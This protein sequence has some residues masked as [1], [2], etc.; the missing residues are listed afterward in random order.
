MSWFI[1]PL[2]P[3]DG[4]DMARLHQRAIMAT[5]EDFYS[6]EQRRSWCFGL[7]PGQYR[8]PDGGHFDVV[9]A[10]AA[11][12]AFCDHIADEVVGLYI[13]PDWQGRGIGSALMRQA[14]GRMIALGTMTAKV[15]AA[16][17]SQTF[18]EKHGYRVTEYTEH[19]TRG[20]LMLPSVRLAKSIA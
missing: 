3:G 8:V 5:H 2:R 15:H 16:L 14:E 4:A 17:S 19:R 10:D 9:E 6:V 7:D 12:I 20:G 18:Y 13:D 1:R 11:V